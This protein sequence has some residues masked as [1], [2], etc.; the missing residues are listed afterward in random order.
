MPEPRVNQPPANQPDDVAAELERL[1]KANAELSTKARERKARIEELETLNA[2][3]QTKT[4]EAEAAR[5]DALVGVP[6]RKIAATVSPVPQLWLAEFAKHYKIEADTD[7]NL[8]VQTLDGK[9]ARDRNEKIVEF[10]PHGLWNL[11]AS[12][13]VITGG[14]K[15]ERSKTFHHLMNY[16]GATGGANTTQR[17]SASARDA[18]QENS[19]LQL[20]L[21]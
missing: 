15:D 18:K 12:D 3:L 13:A 14:T 1:R 2:T 20:G 17:P 8:S 10:T 4:A 16:F 6:L 7:G 19:P 5:H 9:P 21:R 11:L